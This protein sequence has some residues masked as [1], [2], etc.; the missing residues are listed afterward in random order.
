[1]KNINAIITGVAGYVPDYVLNN[2]ELS[3]MVE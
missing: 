2:D 1:M 3:R